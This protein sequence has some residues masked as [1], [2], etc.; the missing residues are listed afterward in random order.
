MST[1]EL[2]RYQLLPSSQLQQDLFS[3]PFTADQIRARKN[4][5]FSSVLGRFR[6]I[7]SRTQQIR[8]KIVL[9]NG[10]WCAIKLA[11]GRKVKRSTADF[12]T[13]SI[14][15]WPHVTIFFNNAPNVQM[16]GISRNQKA[17]SETSTVVKILQRSLTHALRE[18]GMVIQIEA[19]FEQEHFWTII[20]G[21]RGKVSRVRF[22]MVAPNMAN[23]SH[24]LKLDLKQLN[25]DSN[26]HKANLELEAP[27]GGA[28]EIDEKD[29]LIDGCVKYASAGG[30]DIAVKVMG[31]KKEI[32]T[33]T[34]VKT[35][36]IEEMNFEGSNAE[37]LSVM[38]QL[39]Q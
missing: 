39:V 17:F 11:P 4:E 16:I 35:I 15:N 6:A 23:I 9:N 12:R 24:V 13:E 31:F 37:F 5:F 22:E 36:E 21:N 3:A 28:L 32:R 33:S 26:C 34:S 18:F 7:S 38:L 30:G 25:R 29:D 2:Y 10:D 8:E 20:N 19:L 27:P 1:F 14:D